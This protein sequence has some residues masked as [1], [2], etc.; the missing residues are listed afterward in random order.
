MSTRRGIE[1]RSTGL[2]P[3]VPRGTELS[4][5]DLARLRRGE[6]D[7]D[8]VA[9]L[10]DR[11]RA[12]VAPEAPLE[13]DLIPNGTGWRIGEGSL[14]LRLYPRLWTWALSSG[15]FAGFGPTWANLLGV[16]HSLALAVLLGL[17]PPTL[18]AGVVR[19]AVA[20]VERRLW[21]APRVERLL[22]CPS[23]TLVRVAG[24]IASGAVVPTLFRATPS[25]LFKSAVGLAEQTQGIDF[26]LD[27]EDGQRAHVC[28]RRA[29]LL[30]RARRTREAPACGP[31][32]VDSWS[33][34]RRSK[35][36]SDLFTGPSLWRRIIG[37]GRRYEASV[38]PG[39]RVEIC[40]VLHHE[41][42]PDALAPFAR[43]MPVRAALRAGK[44]P[45][46]VRSLTVDS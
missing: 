5:A 22:D 35:L 14:A 28:V 23:G 20:V 41:P 19:G 43:Q 9:A 26:E 38:G 34:R 21:S 45:L 2:A 16:S 18:F 33:E 12:L 37:P 46:L 13:G 39:D 7:A 29:V 27:V 40:G 25:V 11:T 8:T 6:L 10:M 4:R 31:V 24:V 17:V 15:A 36:K 44:Y 30:D 42:A 3:L 1:E 32:S